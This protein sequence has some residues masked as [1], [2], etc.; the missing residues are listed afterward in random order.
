MPNKKEKN[1]AGLP[2]SELKKIFIKRQTEAMA[3]AKMIKKRFFEKEIRVLGISGS[4]RSRNDFAQEDS[5]TEW[6]LGKSLDEAKKLGAETKILKLRDYDI[7]PCKACYSTTNTQCH[8]KCTCYPEGKTGDDM[9]NMLYDMCAWADAII[10]ST[11]VNNFKMS[12]LMALFIDRLISMDGSLKPALEKDMKNA[13]INKLH[14]KY[15]EETA[16]DEF[17]S[18]FLRRLTGKIGGIIVSGH[19]AGAS[20]TI[21]SLFL[22]LN[23]Y[24]LLFPPHSTMYAMGTVCD[25][26]DKDK[27]RLQSPCYEDEAGLLAK[28]IMTAAKIAKRKDDYWWAYDGRAN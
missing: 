21:S 7:R 23:Y 11:P 25:S 14:T 13:E 10:F 22:T 5:T 28:N 20:L 12:S 9:T 26:T 4:N 24:G 3:D 2:D 19:E 16:T 1:A 8:Y 18:G 27:N 17:G 15:I 6:L